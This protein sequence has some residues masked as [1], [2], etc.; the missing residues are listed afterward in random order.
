MLKLIIIF[1]CIYAI[2]QIPLT[3]KMYFGRRKYQQKI[4]DGERKNQE[5]MDEQNK[6]NK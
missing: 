1:I 4:K 3:I 6:N 5:I 2:V